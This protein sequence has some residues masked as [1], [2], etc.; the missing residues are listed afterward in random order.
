MTFTLFRVNYTCIFCVL[1]KLY[2]VFFYYLTLLLCIVVMLLL[3]NVSK[4]IGIK[5]TYGI[6]MTMQV[7]DVI[8][9]IFLT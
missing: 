7:Q 3:V 2:Q 5:T 8:L 4:V 1:C 6:E 9:L